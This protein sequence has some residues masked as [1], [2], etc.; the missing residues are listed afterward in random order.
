MA[1]RN[2]V[3]GQTHIRVNGKEYTT[4][5]KSSMELGGIKR[6][7]QEADHRAGMFS[8][9][10]KSSKIECDVLVTAD[11]SLVELAAID[12]ATVTFEADTGQTYVVRHAY[13]G[14]IISV[15]EGKAK[16]VFMGPPA[17]EMRIG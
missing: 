10:T 3:W 9:A 12:D 7:E 8:E 16:V 2:K 17:E 11:V 14:E 4:A 15:T 13:S 5:G 1:N 6:D